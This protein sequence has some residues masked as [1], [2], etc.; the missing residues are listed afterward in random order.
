MIGI[1]GV[2]RHQFDR[3]RRILRPS[4]DGPGGIPSQ[5]S[6]R[7]SGREQRA[8]LRER[9]ILRVLD[10]IALDLKNE[11]DG[12]SRLAAEVPRIVIVVDK[13][14]LD[15]DGPVAVTG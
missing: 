3:R 7:D 10:R 1:E 12:F 5:R 4:P 11:R 15:G 6:A 14:N 9:N 13:T 2:G 8:V